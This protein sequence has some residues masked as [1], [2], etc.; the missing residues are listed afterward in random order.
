MCTRPWWYQKE[1]V[2]L[3]FIGQSHYA[4]HFSMFS[5]ASPESTMVLESR[6]EQ[7]NLEFLPQSMM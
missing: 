6:V 4:C 3:I 1:A 2:S 5:W 7:A